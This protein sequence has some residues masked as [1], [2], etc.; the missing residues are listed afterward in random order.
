MNTRNLLLETGGKG[1]LV[2]VA[3]SSAALYSAGLWETQFRSVA[4]VHLSGELSKQI[5]EP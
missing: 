5:V 2:K 4:I 3:E 1:I